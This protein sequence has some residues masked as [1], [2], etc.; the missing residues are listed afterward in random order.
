L[1]PGEFCYGTACE[2]FHDEKKINS[3]T[4]AEGDI[5]NER[6]AKVEDRDAV[7]GD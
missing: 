5:D 2:A 4:E 7:S 1:P 3:K 6:T